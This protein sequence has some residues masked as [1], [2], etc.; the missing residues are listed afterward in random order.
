MWSG[1]GAFAGFLVTVLVGTVILAV[2]VGPSSGAAATAPA[3]SGAII[4]QARCSS[5]HGTAGEG[6]AGLPL[7]NGVAVERFPNIAYQIAVNN[8]GRN[9]M[10]SF[11]S[12]LGSWVL[13][14]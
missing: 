8:N 13:L 12:T 1:F 14:S 11:R 7:G 9:A 3:Q 5:C 4:Y 6:G 2:G 10:P